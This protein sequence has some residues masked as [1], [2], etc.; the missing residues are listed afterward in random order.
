MSCFPFTNLHLPS[1]FLPFCPE[2]LG[3]DV[4]GES[5][6]DLA[7]SVWGCKV[8]GVSRVYRKCKPKMLKGKSFQFS[9]CIDSPRRENRAG[10]G[11]DVQACSPVELQVG[12][13]GS[14]SRGPGLFS[15]VEPRKVTPEKNT[16]LRC[17]WGACLTSCTSGLQSDFPACGT[18]V[19]RN[20]HKM[21]M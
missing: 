20:K 1:G 11:S 14:W 4:L 19:L 10:Q 15:P 6:E 18:D 9:K 12:A 2:F 5:G 7:S 13:L 8:W 3:R 21:L 17:E 16:T